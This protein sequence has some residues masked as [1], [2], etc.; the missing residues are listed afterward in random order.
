MIIQKNVLLLN[1]KYHLVILHSRSTSFLVL[2]NIILGVIPLKMQTPSF[3]SY[4]ITLGCK[5]P[6]LLVSG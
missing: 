4:F 6:P 3:P 1:D 5:H 2:Y